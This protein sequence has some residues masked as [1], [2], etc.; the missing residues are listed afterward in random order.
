MDKITM[1]LRDVLAVKKDKQAIWDNEGSFT[2]SELMNYAFKI[3]ARL[4][5][6]GLS[7]GDCV[8]IEL[9]ESKEYIGVMLGV[10]FCGGVYAALD[11]SYPQERLDFIAKDCGA[12]IRITREFLNDLENEQLDMTFADNRPDDPSVIIYTSGSTGNPKGV[13]HTRRSVAES[14]ERMKAASGFC[15]D[16]RYA[17]TAPFT[18]VAATQGIFG[19]LI[20]GASAFLTPNEARRDPVKLADFI[21]EYKITQTFISP[22]MLKLFRQKGKSLRL[23]S[24]GSERVSNIWSSEFRVM[25]VYGSSESAG[26]V[27]CFYP[28][29]EY[30]NTPIGKPLGN[31]KVYILDE[32]GNLANEGEICLAGNFAK[33]YIGLKQKSAETFA[34]NPFKSEDGFD[35]LLH[36]GD[37]GKLLPGGDVLYVNRKDWMIKINGQ[38]V[39]PGEIETVIKKIEGVSDAAVRDF[40]NKYNQVYICAYY[41]GNSNVTEEKIRQEIANKLPS[42]MMPAYFMK[43]QSLPINQNGKLDRKALPKPE[44]DHFTSEYAAPENEKQEKICRAIEELL[45]IRRVGINDDFFRLGGDSIKAVML[46]EKFCDY[47]VSVKDIYQKKTPKGIAELLN[48]KIDKKTPQR[49]MKPA[50]SSFVLNPYE[51]GM[52]LEQKMDQESTEF[53]LSI[54]VFINGSTIEKVKYALEEIFR[55]HEAFHSYYRN[56]NGVPVRII[57]DKLPDIHLKTAVSRHEVEEIVSCVGEPFDLDAEKPPVRADI[58]EIVGG[59][60]VIHL[61]IH[62]IAFDGGSAEIFRRELLDLLVGREY[63]KDSLDLSDISVIDRSKEIKAG[64]EYY[65]ELF[66]DGVPVNEMPVKASRPVE[67]PASD[68]SREFVFDVQKLKKVEEAARKRGLTFF[69]FM[70]S[71]ISMTIGKYCRSEDVVV[72]IPSNMRDE[73]MSGVIGMFVNT[74]PVRIKPVRSKN[75]GSYLAEVQTAV[76]CATRTSYLPFSELVAKFS[77]E[78]DRSRSP[79]FDVSVNYLLETGSC[80]ENNININMISPIQRMKRDFGIT[81]RRNGEVL[82]FNLQYSS[83]LFEDSLVECFIEQFMAT[84]DYLCENED[85]TIAQ[86]LALPKK[87]LK[88]LNEIASVASCEPPIKLFHKLFEKTANDNA[89]KIALIA[90]DK[91]LSYGELNSEANVIANTLINLGI[92]RGNSIILLLPRKSFYFSAMFGVLKAGGAFIPCD[93][94]YPSDRINAILDDSQADY[95]ITTADKVAENVYS[96]TLDIDEL[97]KGKN[98]ETPNAQVSPDDLAYMIYTSGSM[99]RPKGVMLRHLG[100]CNYLMPH[101]ANV[102]FNMLSKRCNTV[103]SVTTVSFDMFFKEAAGA[104]CNGKTL[105]FADESEMNDPRSLTELF[106]NTGADCFN[107]TPS[108]IGQYLEYKP[109]GKALAMC[110]LIMCGGEAYPIA[111]R[112]RLKEVTNAEIINTYGPTEITVSSN[113]AV[114]TNADYITVGRPLLNVHEYVVDPYGELSPP[115]IPGELYIGGMGVA[116]GYKNLPQMTEEKFINYNGERVFRSGDLVKWDKDGNIIVYGR[117]DSQIKLRG[118]RIELGEIERLIDAQPNIGKSVVVVRTINGQEHLCAY[119]TSETKIDI[120]AHKNELGKKL[121]HY[122]TPTAYL[123]MDKLPVTANGKTDTKNLPEPIVIDTQEYVA[124]TNETEKF[125]CNTFEKILHI[126]KVGINDNFFMIGGTSLLA[127]SIIV[128]A[129]IKGFKLNYGDV[130]KLATPKKLAGAV[131]ES[132][133]NDTYSKYDRIFADFDYSAINKVLDKNNLQSFLSGE[134]RDIGNILLTGATGFMGIHLLKQYLEEEKG[135]AYCLVRKGRYKDAALR[136]ENVFFYYFSEKYSDLFPNRVVVIN[137]DVTDENSFH[138]LE[139]YPVDTVFNCAANVKHFSNGTDIEDVNVGGT[140]NCIKFC[141]K[142]GARLIHFSTVSVGGALKAEPENDGKLLDEK[143]LY[144]GQSINNQYAASKLLAER[145]VLSAAAQGYDAKVIRVG[146]LSPRESDGEFQ[147]NFFTNSLMGRLR[148]YMVLGCFPYQNINQPL[149]M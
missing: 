142:T 43:L 14:A 117:L 94:S 134:Q 139:N 102:H 109:F 125:F 88:R 87:Q 70:I 110:K 93:P 56:Q 13:L 112:N 133:E 77:G 30:D 37:I 75:I 3:S 107:A 63:N 118:L 1:Y 20:S 16:D 48:E 64:L 62:H 7:F 86:A 108:R 12:K 31:E 122:M 103:L 47:G 123:R 147:I 11:C 5:K 38:R 49:I 119:F 33:E 65:N 126:E 143:T 69:E 36:T 44:A 81:M 130:F 74:T 91:T 144:F 124:P 46:A 146:T 18:F 71:A 25:V 113:G 2:Y 99:G 84:L 82:D 116:L 55:T 6:N 131:T 78:R 50:G 15:D 85:A 89:D 97:L 100:I 72:G 106:I 114:I 8:T 54:G 92:K 137:G 40:T 90:C 105:V 67:H 45:D 104:L 79:I 111:L 132:R 59:L 136:L 66:A 128:E 28:E 17:L 53:N 80:G 127:T 42:Y 68:R 120:S 129:E 22:K 73:S 9:P 26:G 76:R 51:Q 145:E 23:V 21:D 58:Y 95:I 4:K 148:S 32:N 35:T 121:P 115:G 29:H 96:N 34:K 149:R 61:V 140:V 135:I 83:E 60:A 10:W 141:K 24:T 41:I 101:P 39:E 19:C 52:Y 57:S 27:L 138:E 98:R